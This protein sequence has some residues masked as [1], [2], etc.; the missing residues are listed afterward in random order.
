MSVTQRREGTGQVLVLFVLI[1]VALLGLSALAVDYGVWLLKDREFQNAADSAALAGAAEFNVPPADRS[2]INGTAPMCANARTRAWASLKDS[3]D[4]CAGLDPAACD[5]QLA[6]Y[7]TRDTPPAGD[8]INGWTLWVDT[9]P[10]GAGSSYT[11]QLGGRYAANMAAVFVRV[12]RTVDAFLGHMIMPGGSR[13]TGWAT[14]GRLSGDYALSA[15]CYDDS[16]LQTGGCKSDGIAINGGGGITI[17]NG[18]VASNQS[19]KVTQQ[20]GQGVKVTS[21]DVYLVEGT[22]GPSSWNCPPTVLGGIQDGSQAVPALFMPHMEVPLYPSPLDGTSTTCTG[23]NECVPIRPY[24]SA[25]PGDWSCGGTGEIPCGTWDV[26][27]NA[28]IVPTANDGIPVADGSVSGMTATPAQMTGNLW[29]NIDEESPD[30]AD[31]LYGADNQAVEYEALLGPL[32]TI[33]S[34]AG[35]TLDFTVATTQ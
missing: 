3:L 10:G 22:C 24:G 23:S 27:N 4:L 31:Y 20:G 32:G 33:T 9:P 12:D 13:R 11:T 15:Y 30:I 17:V 26:T 14:A 2:C 28:C 1:L 7:T 8:P 25:T 35:M 5:T 16:P 21:G 6:T 18:D 19:L 34:T 29:Q